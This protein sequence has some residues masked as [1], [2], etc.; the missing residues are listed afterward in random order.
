MKNIKELD[1]S[2]NDD[3]ILVEDLSE[4]EIKELKKLVKKFIVSYL[5]KDKIQTDE[6]WL[7]NKLKE[8]LPEKAENEL[9]IISEEII[10]SVKE[11]N[12]NIND[13]NIACEN[14]KDKESW[15]INKVLDATTGVSVIEYGNYLNEIDNAITNA[16]AQMMRTVS[17]NSNEISRCMNLDGF[18][19]EQYAVN[20]FNME[21]QI[22]GSKYIAEVCVP[23]PG[24]TYG[25][26]SF[27]TV[28]KDSS[29]GKIVHQY[30]FKYGKDSKATINLLKNGNYNNQRFVVPKGQVA[31]VK[32]AFPGKSVESYMGG[33]DKVKTKS[34]SLT[35]EEVKRLQ[36][37]A[38]ERGIL[39]NNN[40]NT[41]NTKEL[42]LNIGKNAGM[43]GLQSALV[44]TGFNLVAKT[45]QGEKIDSNETIELALRTGTDSGI[46]VATSG[47]LKVA[48]EKGFIKL[49]PKGTPA[50]IISN[51]A[52][53]G[54]ENAKI[55]AKVATGELTISQALD[56]MGRTSMAMVYGLGWGTSG[57]ALG[58]ASLA[59][60][61]IV[62]P[63]VG[64]VVGGMV[65]YMAGSK[66]GSSV[67]S[68]L[69]KVGGVVKS[70]VKSAWSGVKSVGSKIGNGI[71]SLGRRIFG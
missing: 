34:K 14:G 24:E 69:N 51:V 66:F 18:I 21:S 38:Q 71:R 68:G 59:W 47:A 61:P 33:T 52:C 22:S 44:T 41:Y 58:V 40:W 6:D 50:G 63:I 17:T 11:F 57:M 45:I 20:T 27:D 46:K 31:E 19:A 49:I 1:I 35:K 43:V 67:Y 37:D 32:K 65:G 29:T 53:L 28:I 9:N 3:Y 12:G 7:F 13:I 62:G 64:G 55:L 8:E 39:P 25:L 26:N 48:V 70:V 5:D 4:K 54:I 42:V 10:K 56:K 16:N 30:Q 2:N 36:L 15:F 60:I 23:G